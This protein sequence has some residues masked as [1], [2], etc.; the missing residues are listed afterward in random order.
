MLSVSKRLGHKDINTTQNVY[1]H[2]I[3]EM[4]ERETSLIMQIMNEAM[5]K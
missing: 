3:K 4:E 1:L 2:V 5:V